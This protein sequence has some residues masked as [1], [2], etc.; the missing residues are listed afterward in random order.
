MIKRMKQNLEVHQDLTI[1]RSKHL[2]MTKSIGKSAKKSLSNTIHKSIMNLSA[3]RL[4]TPA[5]F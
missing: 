1:S 5:K 3:H 4:A 2:D